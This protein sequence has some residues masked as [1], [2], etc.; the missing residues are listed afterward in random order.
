MKAVMYHYV[1]QGGETPPFGYYHLEREDFAAQLD[2]FA[3]RYDLLG[4]EAF[5]QTIRGERVPGES[6]VVLTFDDGLA[7]HYEHVLPELEARDMWGIFYVPTGPYLDG[8]ALNVHRVHALLG[9]C[10]GEAVAAELDDIVD[11]PMLDDD[12]VDAFT[13]VVYQRQDNDDPTERVK[14][15]LNYYIADQYR[16]E[17]LRDLEDALLGGQSY[18]DDLYMTRDQL[19]EL[20]DVGMLVGSHTVTHRVMSTLSAAKQRAEVEGSFAFLDETLDGLA[21]RTYCHPYGGTH[22]YDESTL[23]L[24]DEVGCEFSFDVD[25]RDLTMTGVE[26]ASQRLPRYDCNEFPRGESTVSLGRG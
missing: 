5:L 18:H 4:R 2:Y 6:E 13:G 1:N 15:V 20:A 10:G 23:D 25:A 8:T 17:V 7:D 12:H 16:S 26:T 19:R 11:E 9:A 14:E 3:E 22:S 21:V 24:L